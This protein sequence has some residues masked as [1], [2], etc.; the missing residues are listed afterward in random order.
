MKTAKT[1]SNTKF[2]VKGWLPIVAALT[3]VLMGQGHA[4]IAAEAAGGEIAIL[5]RQSQIMQT[6]WKVS[7]VA[8]TDPAVADVQV[9]TTNQVLIQ[10]L[11]V[12][13]TDILLWSEDETHV[14]QKKVSVVMDV[15][16]LTAVVGGLFPSSSLALSQSGENLIVKGQ[17][18]NAI[19]AQQLQ[20]Y[21]E[22][23]KISFVDMSDVAGVQQVQ[24]QVRV[25]EV[26]KSA[27][28]SLGISWI[29]RGSDFSSGVSPGGGIRS[30]LSDGG[31]TNTIQDSGLTAFGILPRAD[32]AFFLDALAENQY[33]RLLA[34]PT[35]IA[36]N[37]EEASFLA[38]GEYP[39]PVPQSGT[40]AQA[41]ITIEYKE[42][43]VRLNFKPV[44][45]GDNTIRLYTAPEVSELDYAN[46]TSINGTV[47]PGVL[48]RKAET[49]IELR[50][51]QSF[52]IAGLL[53]DSVTATNSS[54]PGLGNLPV[55]GP[56]FRS[57]RYQQGET[58]LVIL[59]TANL[60]EP[61]DI[62]PKTAPLPGFL[63]TAPNDWELY[64][65]GRIEG[66]QPA[67]L[68]GIDAEWLKRLGLDQVSGPG[69]WDTYES[70]APPSRADIIAD[71]P[72][73]VS[74]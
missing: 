18:K 69:A 17:H 25:A 35:L 32:I 71:E 22:K 70:P 1:Q 30:T 5:H 61:L 19:H 24:L 67:G 65:E 42:Y 56:L 4:A 43:G 7:R 15:D 41:T 14:L 59:V 27:I 11:T 16:T 45:L 2:W 68:D 57:V 36:L 66:Q 47:V 29:Q 37:G 50:S 20:E 33:L 46:G 64:L 51:G 48:S 3:A 34:N 49:T 9:L 21:L 52:A 73:T 72:A 58:E 40:G 28:K 38:G 13:T 60:V 63:H 55:L 10:G 6:P 39:I 44:V 23:M 54:I 74:Q 53:K 31:G 8:V 26:S 62:D 12:G